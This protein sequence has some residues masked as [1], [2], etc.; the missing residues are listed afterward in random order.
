MITLRNCTNFVG[1]YAYM[2]RQGRQSAETREF[3]MFPCFF[4]LCT[5][6]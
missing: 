4:L 3:L 6:M 2:T 1:V 5:I